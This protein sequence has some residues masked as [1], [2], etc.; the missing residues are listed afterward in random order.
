MQQFVQCRGRVRRVGST[1]VVPAVS[2]RA[3]N[4]IEDGLALK[5]NTKLNYLEEYFMNLV[6]ERNKK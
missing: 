6:N 1:N 2:L 3:E 4:T 5:M